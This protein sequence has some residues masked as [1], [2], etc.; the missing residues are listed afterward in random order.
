MAEEILS[1]NQES[2]KARK[3]L[4]IFWF[5][6]IGWLAAGVAAPITTFAIKFGLF[7]EYGYKV[8]T[9]ELGNVTGM[10]IALN[11]WGIISVILIVFAFCTII[12]EVIEAYSKKYSMAKQCL[13]GL[14]KRI[15][16]IVI[17]IG[18]C[19]FLRNCLDQLIFCLW[20]LGVSQIVAIPLN[21]LPKWKAEKKGEENYND[22]I[23]SAVSLIKDYK[24]SRKAGK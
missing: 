13:V 20:V 1:E 15:M 9:D 10:N 22:L 7:S 19:Y 8:T 12:D 14:K 5:R 6:M 23:S 18:I 24:A 16:P 21:P 11:G 2:V 17:A 4:L 3:D